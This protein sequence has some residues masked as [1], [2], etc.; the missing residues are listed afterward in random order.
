LLEGGLDPALLPER[1]LGVGEALA[2]AVLLGA[3][4]LSQ[5]GSEPLVIDDLSRLHARVLVEEGSGGE[6]LARVTDLDAENGS[7]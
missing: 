1:A 2:I 4:D 6:K 3:S 5:D 7:K